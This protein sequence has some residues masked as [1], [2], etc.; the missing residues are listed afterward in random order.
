MSDI[1]VDPSGK[2]SFYGKNFR[3]ALGRCGVST[4]KKED[5]GSTPIG[6]F[7]LRNVYYRPDRLDKPKTN[8][9]VQELTEEDGW[10]D[11]INHSEYNTFV[12]L[13]H[14]GSYEK[15]WRDDEIYNI[16]VPVGYNDDP[17]IPGKGSA[18]F[19]HIARPEYTPTDGCVAL[20]TE[21]LLEILKI[22]NSDTR[23]CI[24]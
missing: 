2:L 15:L 22:S 14:E 4:D 11:D 3:C 1:F 9:P 16:I 8:L 19:M 17:A 18:I 5:D 7:F 13:P 23:I 10:C 20:N 12:K 21:E 6:C 24:E